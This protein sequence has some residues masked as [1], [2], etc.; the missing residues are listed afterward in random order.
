M[1]NYIPKEKLSAYER[2]ELAA[3]DEEEQAARQRVTEAANPV[4]AAPPKPVVSDEELATIR[5]E[6]HAGGKKAGY[7]EGFKTGLSAGFEEGMRNASAEIA[8]ISALAGS[9]S[10]S[11]DE[12]EAQVADDLLALAIDIARQVVRNSLRIKPELVVTTVRE[13]IASLAN[14]HGHPVLVLN[15]EDAGIVRQQLSEQLAH[16]AWRIIED[17]T[18]ERG[19]CKVE[20]GGSEVNALIAQRWQRVVEQFGSRADWLGT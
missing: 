8:K 18:V 4:P 5:A 20:S 3:F 10:G 1:S 12:L 15:P 2:W 7:E 13:A 11:I 19:G 14:P 16:T 6:A 17:P 9:F